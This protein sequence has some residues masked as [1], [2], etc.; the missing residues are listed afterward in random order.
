ML[1]RALFLGV[2]GLACSNNGSTS[3]PTDDSGGAGGESS[4]GSTAT[5]GASGSGNGG[6]GGT[7]TGGSGTGGTQAGAGGEGGSGEGGESGSSAGASGAAGQGGGAGEDTCGGIAGPAMIELDGFCIDAT[8]V[9]LGDYMLFFDYVESEPTFEQPAVCSW[10]DSFVPNA[11]STNEGATHP[12]RGVDWC[13][14]YAYCA[15]AGKRLCGN[16]SGGAATYAEPANADTSQWFSACSAD[17]ATAFPYG[18]TYDPQACNGGDYGPDGVGPLPVGSVAT[19]V[20]GYPGIYDMSG[21]VWEWEDSCDGSTGEMDL[22]RARGGAFGNGADFH[23][24]DY[25]GFSPARNFNAG[26]TGIRCCSR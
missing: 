12:V 25:G 14:A 8:E 6:T 9:T 10:N 16:P 19:C 22:C 11:T 26:P 1:R 7:S 20:G 5:G 13:D 18:D 15:W 21:N 17:G 23:R 4:G 2:L 24:C 3:D